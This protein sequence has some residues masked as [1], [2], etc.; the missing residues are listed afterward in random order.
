[1]KKLF[2]LTI[3][4]VTQFSLLISQS[5]LPD[6][7]IF[8][9]QSQIDS[10]QINYPGCTE[11]EGD[12]E[13]S[14]AE[15]FNLQGLIT[16]NSIGGELE[17]AFTSRLQNLTGL[18]SLT[19]V[20]NNVKV[21]FN[22]SITSLE[23]LNN[24]VSIGGNLVIGETYSNPVSTKINSLEAL[25]N[26]TYIS[27]GLYIKYCD[28]LQSLAGLEN[29]ISGTISNINI[30]NNPILSSCE[31]Q[32]V[33]DFLSNPAGEINIY[34]NAEGCKNP[35][36]IANACGISLNCLPFGSYHFLSQEEIDNFQSDYQ[37]CNNLNGNVIIRGNNIRYLSGLN[38][39][40]SIEK[41]LRIGSGWY[42]GND[43]LVDLAGLNNLTTIGGNLSIDA[44][45]MLLS[46]TGLNNLDSVGG[47]LNIYGNNQLSS[48][49]GLENLVYIGESLN[50]HNTIKLEDLSGLNNL[51]YL[52]YDI[53]ITSNIGFKNFSG[54]E[55]INTIHGDLIVFYNDSLISLSG[56]HNVSRIY[57]NVLIETM[58]G[59]TLFP[60]SNLEEI[61]GGLEILNNDYLTSLS[62]F[63]NLTTVIGHLRIR[64][65]QSLTSISELNNLTIL[66][67]DL[68]I[69]HN[70]SLLSLDG[71]DNLIIDSINDITIS[72]NDSLY[73]CDALSICNYLATPTG[74]VNIYD[75]ASGCNS[76]PEIASDCGFIMPCLP[77]GNYIFTNQNDIDNFSLDYPNCNDLNGNTL[78]KTSGITN[79]G[80]L[81]QITSIENN[82]Y[83]QNCYDLINLTGLENLNSTGGNFQIFQNFNLESTEGLSGLNYIGGS[84]TIKN[85]EDLNLIV[86]FNQLEAIGEDLS[87]DFNRTVYD[88]SGF[89]GLQT[90]GKDF[91]IYSINGIRN[92]SSFY[93]LVS[94]GGDL[95]IKANR[96]LNS[97]SGLDS[98]NNIGGNLFIGG[99]DSLTSLSGLDNI[100]NNSI[101]NL[102]I[103]Q[104]ESLSECDIENICAYLVSPGGTV[105]IEDN[106]DGCNDRNE[107]EYACG[108]GIMNNYKNDVFKIYPN[109]AHHNLT[110][111]TNEGLIINRI[112][113]YNYIG[114]RV[115]SETGNNRNLNI[116]SLCSGVY[117][118]E[119]ESNNTLFRN[120]VIVR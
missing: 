99:H 75:N 93:N 114:Q 117:V 14:G 73:S 58:Y 2:L 7:I 57:G 50:I 86:G 74:I 3:I 88:I 98:L 96:Y 20:S 119:I 29:V 17:L 109:P 66:S 52:G 106:N 80:G 31:V 5:C 24:L 49:T 87:L 54:L 41:D 67:D 22:D 83:I 71:L 97:L 18:N 23:G 111:I 79:L 38:N 15:I 25:S 35:P 53:D 6:G 32:C 118:I 115:F 105:I 21:W 92:L 9:E 10:F 101:I 85:N 107:I 33:C 36:Q 94:V 60:F 120:K 37:S 112:S 46:L 102:T 8:T 39:I 48:L 100:D 51:N 70:P 27:G 90:I 62:G 30:Y 81:T 16:L 64:N 65:N 12:V 103:R 19:S 104:N 13:I 72:N 28:S 55:S 59:T 11:I 4:L 61:G 45:D 47:R 110:I 84:F 34:A 63:E 89:S 116:S 77:F 1:M 82:L 113:I 95:T 78:I 69:E 44:N 40:S 68:I 108:V 26:L 56:L 91:K 43:S 76:P 42:G